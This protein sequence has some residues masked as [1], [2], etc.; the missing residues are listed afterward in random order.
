MFTV[1]VCFI[2]ASIYIYICE[3]V[4]VSH[5]CVNV[6]ECVRTSV[7]YVCECMWVCVCV[8]VY[9]CVSVS[10]VCECVSV[11][12]KCQKGEGRSSA[13]LCNENCVSI[14]KLLLIKIETKIHRLAWLHQNA[15]S[16]LSPLNISTS[17][18]LLYFNYWRCCIKSKVIYVY[19]K[20]N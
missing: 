6:R 2:C 17:N 13:H 18:V 4:C 3:C 10:Y 20:K 8:C 16:Y 11:V 12:G 5:I 9:M 7:S 15:N 19:R 1:C 14:L